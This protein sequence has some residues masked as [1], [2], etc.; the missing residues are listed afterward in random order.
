[1]EKNESEE[2]SRPGSV[3]EPAGAENDEVE[4]AKREPGDNEPRFRLKEEIPEQRD[5]DSNEKKRQPF[6]L[7]EEEKVKPAHDH[8]PT[9]QS[10]EDRKADSREQHGDDESYFRRQV[11]PH[12]ASPKLPETLR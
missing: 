1:M 4:E 2:V 9:R 6:A 7:P 11:I 5:D 8:R 12:E 3:R 10:V